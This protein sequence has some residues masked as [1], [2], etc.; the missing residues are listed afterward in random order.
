[1]VRVLVAEDSRTVRELITAILRADPEIRIAGEAKNGAE[2]LAMTKSLR[3]D[4]VTM[5]IN[6]PMMD[7][8][9]ATKRIMIEVPTPIIIVSGS[10]DVREVEVSMQ[11]LRLGALALV[12]KPV[13][14]GSPEFDEASRQLV[15][16]V[17]A[18][19][20]VRV[21]HHWPVRTAAGS[22]PEAGKPPTAPTKTRAVAVAA[23]TG[24]PA[25]LAHLLSRLP[26]D[27]PVPI[28]VV[29]H[30]T[31]GFVHGLVA[32]LNTLCGPRVK[33]AEDGERLLPS[34]VYVAGDDGHL[35]V[36][37][38]THIAVSRESPMDGHRPSASHLF[39]SVGRAFGASATA[40]VLT[41][42]GRDGVAGLDAVR[43]AGGRVIVQD[44]ATSVV[45]GMPG[46]VVEAGLADA[47]LSLSAIGDYLIALA[48]APP[49]NTRNQE[50]RWSES[51]SSKTAPPR[52]SG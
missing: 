26:A 38:S 6:M 33:V 51:S 15:W 11:A 28:L 12:A 13:G 23:S 14:P 16:T 48:E 46:A 40:I 35:G 49:A 4:V 42:M 25:A 3:P 29:Q 43:N 24:G 17:K 5:D 7:G 31:K 8:F 19:A 20:E 47:I 30:M 21:V 18:M 36:A 34:V 22:R 27:F 52:P 9:E 50:T 10:L 45:F 37:S 41:G 44:A 39:A 2:A 1:M 32:W